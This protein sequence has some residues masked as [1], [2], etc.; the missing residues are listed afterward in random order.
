MHTLVFY[1]LR[2]FF[3][4]IPDILRVKSKNSVD[5]DIH[6]TEKITRFSFELTYI[7]QTT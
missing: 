1:I 5:V 3:Y 2:F 6:V 4:S 7:E